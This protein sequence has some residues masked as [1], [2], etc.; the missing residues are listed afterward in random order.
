MRRKR[1]ELAGSLALVQEFCQVFPDAGVLLGRKPVPLVLGVKVAKGVV[2]GDRLFA[3]LA[4][5]LYIASNVSPEFFAVAVGGVDP[6]HHV[7]IRRLEEPADALL[8]EVILTLKMVGYDPGADPGLA[9]DVREGRV[10]ESAIGDG[11]DGGI[12][13]LA[14]PRFFDKGRLFGRLGDGGSPCRCEA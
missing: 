8:D 13:D 9:R 3:M 11:P 6:R 7:G 2:Q 1:T 10:G 12:D 4:H 5:K 14:A